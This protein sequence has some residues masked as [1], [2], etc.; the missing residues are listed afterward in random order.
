MF[1]L[2]RF[3]GNRYVEIL[4][5]TI[6]ENHASTTGASSFYT[7]LIFYT[8]KNTLQ[9]PEIET[10]A[11]CHRNKQRY[12]PC[13]CRKPTDFAFSYIKESDDKQISFC[14]ALLCCVTNNGMRNR[15]GTIPLYDENSTSN[16]QYFGC[17]AFATWAKIL[18]LWVFTL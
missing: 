18:D 5:P 11:H 1:W 14:F 2:M 10:Q 9:H 17:R 3:K 7:Q 8:T 12:L 6:F 4:Y 16:D 15:S 13:E